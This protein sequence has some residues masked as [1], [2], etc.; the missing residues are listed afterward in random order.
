MI[1]AEV[2]MALYRI[3]LYCIDFRCK[4]NF[5]CADCSLFHFC[6]DVFGVEPWEW[7]H[8]LDKL[9]EEGKDDSKGFS[10]F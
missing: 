8:M 5:S 6:C 2:K 4:I 1:P 3:A 10:G 7:E 9:A